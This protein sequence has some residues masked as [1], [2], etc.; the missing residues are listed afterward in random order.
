MTNYN[1]RCEC[2]ADFSRWNLKVIELFPTAAFTINSITM[3]R[4]GSCKVAYSTDILDGAKVAMRL[5]PDA[6]VMV[7]SM[8]KTA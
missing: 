8:R 2:I 4:Y 7:R 3:D 1:V 6:H 5:T